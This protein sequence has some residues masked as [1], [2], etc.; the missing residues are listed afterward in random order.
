MKPAV[1]QVDSSFTL[2]DMKIQYEYVNECSCNLVDTKK[3]V[4]ANTYEGVWIKSIVIP[5]RK[6]QRRRSW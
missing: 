6:L 4:I 1:L 3:L 5:Y 2:D